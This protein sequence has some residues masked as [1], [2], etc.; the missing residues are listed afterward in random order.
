MAAPV[1]TETNIP[2]NLSA[3]GERIATAARAADREAA[4][5]TLVAISKAHPAAA[6]KAA[7]VAGHRVFGEN[8]V[9]EAEDKW[10]VLKE[11]FTDAHLHLVGGLQRNKVKAAVALFDVIQVI[12]RPKLAR[13]VAQ[14]MDKSGRRPDCFI[15]V[16]TGEET[17]KGGVLPQGADAFIVACRDEFQLPMVGLMCIPPV[18]EEAALHFALLRDLAQ[19]NGLQTLSMGMSGDFETA[20]RFGATHVRVGTGIFGE[21]PPYKADE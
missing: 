7:L 16:N 19:R 11:E 14:E 8:R 15:Q 13:A 18:N 1:T 20:I 10:P 9:Q 6:A 21:R 3:V 2:E 5:V 4:A 17:Q 12:D